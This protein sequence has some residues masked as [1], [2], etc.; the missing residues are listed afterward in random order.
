VIKPSIGR[1]VW[2]YH[3]VQDL[4]D[5]KQPLAAIVTHV[6]D[7]R[8]VNL[9]IFDKE[10]RTGHISGSLVPLLQDEDD[11]PKTGGFATWMPYQTGQAAKT[12]SLT[13]QVTEHEKLIREL[14]DRIVKLE[15]R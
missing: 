6:H 14:F 3:S 8:M 15:N 1:I 4:L 11:E 9:S 13:P 2:F 12:D 5:E 10:G 7:D